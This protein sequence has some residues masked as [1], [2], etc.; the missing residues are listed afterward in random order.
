MQ[1]GTVRFLTYSGMSVPLLESNE[2]D[3]L[4]AYAARYLRDELERGSDVT[5]Q[6]RGREWEVITP[7]NREGYF[8]SDN[9]GY[10]ILNP[11][12]PQFVECWNCGDEFE[13]DSSHE[14]ESFEDEDEEPL[15]DEPPFGS[16]PE[17]RG[18]PD[19]SGTP[20]RAALRE[21]SFRQGMDA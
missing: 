3:E 16:F 17:E 7:E 12:V 21:L 11:P 14:C 1:T 5:T 8:V 18:Y 10:L 9:D 19:L 13:R 15:D 6:E 20:Y 2:L 4:R